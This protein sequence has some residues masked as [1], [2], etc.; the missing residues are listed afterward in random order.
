MNKEQQTQAITEMVE[1][2]IADDPSYFLVG[3]Q[4][5]PT[6][7]IRVYL[8]ADGGVS[9]ERCVSYNRLLYKQLEASSIFPEGDFSL[10]V[11]SPGLDEPLKMH[12]QYLKNIGRRVEVT[13]LDGSQVSGVLKE[14]NAELIRVETE[15]GKGKKK[16]IELREIP[17]SEIKATKILI[18]F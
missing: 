17:F 1:Q 8:D 18:V 4:I 11:S 10:E 13:R 12:R 6:H 15:K 14:A 9:I 16:E 3:V 5:R 2:I 7:N